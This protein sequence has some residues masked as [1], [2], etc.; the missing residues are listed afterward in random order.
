[1]AIATC[2]GYRIIAEISRKRDYF[3]F[4]ELFFLEDF[5]IIDFFLAAMF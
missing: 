5:F 2:P 1:V 4:A 3:F